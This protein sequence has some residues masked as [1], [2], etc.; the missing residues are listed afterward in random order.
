MRRTS[1]VVVGFAAAG[2]SVSAAEATMRITGDRGGLVADYVERFEAA[3]ANGELVIIDGRVPIS[4]YIGDS[5]FATRAGLRHAKRC[6]R[7]SR[8]LAAD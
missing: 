8:R 3:R 5:H 7:L 2:I 4:L 6:A 1:L